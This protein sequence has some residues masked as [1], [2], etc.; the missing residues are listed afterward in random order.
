MSAALVLAAALAAAP[1][2]ETV[3]FG[4]FGTV[5]LYRQSP[6]PSRVAL[7]VSGDGG[8]NQGVV[9]MAQSLAEDDALVAGVDIRPYL[10]GLDASKGA[11]SFPAGDF[12]A[13]G[14]FLEKKLEFPAYVNPVLVGYSSGA[15]LVYAVLTQAPP[16]TFKGA[17][18]LGFCPDLPVAKGF[19]KGHGLVSEK[20]PKGGRLFQAQPRLEPPW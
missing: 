2:G 7:F 6:H 4:S 8:W 5:H 12:E 10:K 13:L 3:H 1:T 11:C 14:Q 15:T 17:L 9:S 16:N 18:R 20:L 19:C